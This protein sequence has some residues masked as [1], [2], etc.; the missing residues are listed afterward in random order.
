MGRVV[1]FGVDTGME[2]SGAGKTAP[3]IWNKLSLIYFDR[4]NQ[5]HIATP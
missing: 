5:G 1:D 2:K 4:Y 3:E